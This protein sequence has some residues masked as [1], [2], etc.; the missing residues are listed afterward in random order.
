MAI[1]SL[2]LPLRS[3]FRAPDGQLLLHRP[4]EGEEATHALLKKESGAEHW[5][6]MGAY[7]NREAA[8]RKLEQQASSTATFDLLVIECEPY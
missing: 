4:N 6:I 1:P 5:T 8:E 3:R 7:G 2:H